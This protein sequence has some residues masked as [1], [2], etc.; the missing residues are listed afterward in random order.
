MALI[1]AFNIIQQQQQ[2][3]RKQRVFRDRLHPLDA[4]DDAEIIT[5]YR[6][7]RHRITNLYDLIGEELEP[8]TQRNHAI[9]AMIQIF[10]ALRYF[11]CG[12]FQTVVGDGLGIHRSSVSRIVTKVTDKLCRMRRRFI[13]FPRTRERMQEV[14]EGFHEIAH[15]PRVIG[16]IDGTLISIKAPTRDE[17]LFVSRKGGHSLNILAVCD[18]SLKFT[19]VVAKYPGASNDAFIWLNC[20]LKQKFDNGDIVP[21]WLLGD[22]G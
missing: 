10:C 14:S 15:F 17:H 22:S 3:I 5:R 4:Y 12:S 16:A 7:P 21:G 11:A 13:Q 20:N 2:N 1:V 9:P 19:Y 18:S 6:L 8:Q